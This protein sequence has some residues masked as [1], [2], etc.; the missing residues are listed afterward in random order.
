MDTY[1]GAQKGVIIHG[2]RRTFGRWSS[3][4]LALC[5]TMGYLG[6]LE[7]GFGNDWWPQRYNVAFDGSPTLRVILGIIAITLAVLL[8]IPIKDKPKDISSENVGRMMWAYGGRLSAG[9][10][11][12]VLGLFL[13]IGTYQEHEAPTAGILVIF[14]VWVIFY[15][16]GEIFERAQPTHGG[17]PI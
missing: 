16:F 4:N 10:Y 3:L 7:V 15:T 6:Y 5:V 12:A 1:D 14:G 11:L 9:A 8:A 2:T 13:S 17:G